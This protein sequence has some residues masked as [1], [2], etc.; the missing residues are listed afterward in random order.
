MKRIF[1]L[2]A[3]GAL[4]ALGAA[5]TQAAT[6]N[7]W[8]QNVNIAVTA[9][10]QSG[11]QIIQGTLPTKQFLAFLSGLTNT[12]LVS[13]Q[14]VVPIT[15]LVATNLTVEVTNLWFLPMTAAPPGD[16]PR[17]YTVTT[18]YVVTPDAGAHYYTN[19]INFTNDLLITRARAINTY[20]FQ[21]SINLTNGQSAY[22]F[23]GLP[24]FSVTAVWTTNYG[25]DTVFTLTG[26]EYT[27]V[28]GTTTIYTYG[29]NPDFT[30]QPGAK[31]MYVTP[32]VGGT[33]QPSRFVVRYKSGKANVDVDVSSLL[34]ETSG[35]P[36][37]VVSQYAPYGTQFAMDGFSSID[38][39]NVYGATTY[40]RFMGY[41]TQVWSPISLKGTVV[42]PSVLKQRN[43]I[44]GYGGAITGQI[45]A[46]TFNNSTTILKG[47]FT[48]NGGRLE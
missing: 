36:Y 34:K 25:S 18:N 10:V 46:R 32:I 39:N 4:L 26:V 47:T 41:D 14:V 21:N 35:S 20:Q 13:S 5:Q 3:I 24:A 37:L 7:Y 45:Q 9:Y 16:L 31:L 19:N 6:T 2:G 29:A 27:N 22:F 28:V 1:E 44:V 12:A 33:N 23:P 40:L 43:M 38:F 42:S 15:N 30:K 48:I 17:S 11:G 8:V